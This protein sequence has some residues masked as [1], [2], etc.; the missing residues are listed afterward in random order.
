M[1]T[2]EEI[3]S[4]IKSERESTDDSEEHKAKEEFFKFYELRESI[5][6]HIESMIV[7]N[8]KNENYK[9]NGIYIME[10]D[11]DPITHEVYSSL[12]N[13]FFEFRKNVK[14]LDDD[15]MADH[16]C[17]WLDRYG[18]RVTFNMEP[19]NMSNPNQKEFINIFR[20][21]IGWR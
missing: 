15:T 12:G 9:Y 21:N 11:I 3:R 5:L 13:A 19:F 10:F 17:S 18:Y 6:K 1:I 16:I 20:I 14:Y 2:A 4:R 7:N 8:Y